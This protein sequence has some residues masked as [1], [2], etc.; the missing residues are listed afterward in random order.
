MFRCQFHTS[1]TWGLVWLEGLGFGFEFMALWFRIGLLVQGL[2]L[3]YVG[4]G[5]WCRDECRIR[6]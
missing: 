1:Q 5:I 2:G 4:S 6:V 3:G